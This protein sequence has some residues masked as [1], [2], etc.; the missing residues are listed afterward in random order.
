[1]IERANSVSGE[2]NIQESIKLI[3]SKGFRALSTKPFS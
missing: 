1:M 3:P 2:I